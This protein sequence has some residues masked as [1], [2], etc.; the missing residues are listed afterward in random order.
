MATLDLG[1]ATI[2]S[3]GGSSSALLSA[4]DSTSL[5]STTSTASSI[6]YALLVH[7]LSS[8]TSAT[9]SIDNR[10]G[11]ATVIS[12]SSTTSSRIE[13]FLSRTL[14]ST[15]STSTPS[16]LDILRST[17]L[18]SHSHAVATIY[19]L[20][21]LDLCEPISSHTGATATGHT[22]ALLTNTIVHASTGVGTA[23]LRNTLNR[24]TIHAKTGA[25][26]TAIVILHTN[27]IHAISAGR[28]ISGLL[29]PLSVRPV[30]AQSIGSVRNS[31]P[32]GLL[33]KPPK[34]L[35]RTTL[36]L[37]I[38]IHPR[39]VTIRGV[40]INGSGDPIQNATVTSQLIAS[41]DNLT[42]TSLSITSLNFQP[43]ETSTD[44]LGVWYLNLIPPMDMTDLLNPSDPPPYYVITVDAELDNPIIITTTSFPY[45]FG[46]VDINTITNSTQLVAMSGYLFTSLGKPIVHTR[47]TTHIS[48]QVLDT[49]TNTEILPSDEFVSFTNE[50]GK[51]VFY[52][53][54]NSRYDQ[55]L[56]YFSL[57]EDRG[58]V[59]KTFRVPNTSSTIN[60][61]IVQLTVPQTT[62]LTLDH[63]GGDLVESMQYSTLDGTSTLITSL[64]RIR[65]ILFNIFTATNGFSFSPV[66]TFEQI[67]NHLSSVSI[68]QAN[69]TNPQSGDLYLQDDVTVQQSVTA[70]KMGSSEFPLLQVFDPIKTPLN[71]APSAPVTYPDLDPNATVLVA[72]RAEGQVPFVRRALLNAN[73]GAGSSF[74]GVEMP[75]TS[76]LNI[77]HTTVFTQKNY[78]E[79]IYSAR[80]LSS[81][82]RTFFTDM[83][84]C[85]MWQSG[86]AGHVSGTQIQ[87]TF[88]TV[89]TTLGT[90]AIKITPLDSF[91]A[92]VLP[93]MTVSLT[94]G[95]F[96]V[97]FDY[98]DSRQLIYKMYY[99]I[100][101]V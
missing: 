55:P 77:F 3:T 29:M 1:S 46:I 95:G 76:A 72:L 47:V 73:T 10:L 18:T 80:T 26:A 94:I 64:N 52:L 12:T 16:F 37:G 43:T 2:S 83:H 24:V 101:G 4:L 38:F 62:A 100:S 51:Y 65:N 5:S 97:N 69:P 56:A 28:A 67:L 40:L 61:N 44:N 87:Y 30:I 9:A 27:A 79:D 42:R 45:I 78:W 13:S 11:S 90:M 49:L 99:R 33:I 15:T 34:L 71:Y 66:A 20:S 22:A 59:T 32:L 31:T 81:G 68:L 75:Y 84:G 85:I 74:I 98:S 88:S 96:S 19:M 63:V 35:G 54:P 50:S 93:H 25:H 60:N 89:Y 36:G 48:Q 39:A 41:S 14:S 58:T 82:R 70:N 6:I 92:S 21:A 91:T 17:I 7:T 57:Y 86:T 23:H 53:P 8:T